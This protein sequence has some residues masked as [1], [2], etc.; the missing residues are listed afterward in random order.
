MNSTSIIID[1][2]GPYN[3]VQ[4]KLS[5]KKD[6]AD[7]LYMLIGKTKHEELKKLQYIGIAKDLSNR[8]KNNH[9]AIKETSQELNIWL[10]E[11]SSYGVPGRKMKSINSGLDLAEWAHI[12]FL[13]P[14]LNEKKKS[15]PPDRPVTVLNR[16]WHKDYQT[17]FRKRPHKDWPDLIDY[18]DIEFG[19]KTCWF[20]G[21]VERWKK[22]DFR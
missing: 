21:K 4:V 2:Y 3:L 5:L 15:T 16:W 20:G 9:Y 13:Q 11:I 1:W 7:G 18:I 17:P 6:F 12:F 19:A 22:K 8:I 14:S 10:G